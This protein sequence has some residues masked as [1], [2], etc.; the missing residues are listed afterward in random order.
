MTTVVA[1]SAEPVL[2]GPISH[3][4]DGVEVDPTAF[5]V[6]AWFTEGVDIPPADGEWVVVSWETHTDRAGRDTWWVKVPIGP[7]TSVGSLNIQHHQ[8]WV[9]VT[10]SASEKPV[11]PSGILTVI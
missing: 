7:G 2:L 6:E 8:C 4:V 10:V 11:L 3:K 1:T 5:P 9:R